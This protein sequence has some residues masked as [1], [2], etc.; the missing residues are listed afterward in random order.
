MN[1][2]SA[3]VSKQQAIEIWSCNMR[4]CTQKLCPTWC[5]FG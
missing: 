4:E 5:L 1:F 3:D 2:T